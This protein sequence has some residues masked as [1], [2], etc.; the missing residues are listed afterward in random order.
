LPSEG[1]D[2][3]ALAKPTASHSTENYPRHILSLYVATDHKPRYVIDNQVINVY[4]FSYGIPPLRYPSR[5]WAFKMRAY[6]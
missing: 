3:L 4:R 6:L 1:V 2:L 5:H